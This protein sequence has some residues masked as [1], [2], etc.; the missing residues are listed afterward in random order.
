M[1]WLSLARLL[2]LTAFLKKTSSPLSMPES[3]EEI[4]SFQNAR[5]KLIKRLR[6]KRHRD[7][8]GCFVVDT[9]RDLARALDQGYTVD[10]ALFCPPA[11]NQ[12]L[13]QRLAEQSKVYQVTSAIMQKASYRDTPSDFVAVVQQKP[14]PTIDEIT[15]LNAPY[16]LGLVNLNKP[17]NIGALLRTADATGFKSI[18]IIDT[19]LDIY[20]PNVI[21]SSTGT[22]FLGNSYMGSSQQAIQFLKSH[23]YQIIIGHL[24]GN[25]SLFDVNFKEQ[26]AIILGTEETG[27][28][29]EWV[30]ACDEA[31]T[32][33]MV[34]YVADSLNVS[35][36]GAV[37][38]Y[39]ALR[40]TLK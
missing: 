22:S 27:L 25:K 12:T 30:D 37:F 34:G 23:G 17:G 24:Q 33:P 10:F 36:S 16:I 15:Y 29:Q 19:A 9:D 14:V 4:T 28:S 26:T 13:L 5:L 31:V 11:S 7:Q 6:N 32:I 3:F 40:Q 39:E 18:F 21:R 2:S 1:I 20:N 8:E 35:V 38:M